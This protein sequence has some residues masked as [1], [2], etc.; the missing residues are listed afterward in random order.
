MSDD[1]LA[2]IIAKTIKWTAIV[3]G[4]LLVVDIVGCALILLGVWR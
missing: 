1:P 3:V 4:A 2:R